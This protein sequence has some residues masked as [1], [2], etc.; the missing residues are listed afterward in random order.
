MTSFM[1]IS[2]LGSLLAASVCFAQVG[3]YDSTQF[4]TVYKNT[5]M[6]DALVKQSGSAYEGAIEHVKIGNHQAALKLWDETPLPQD[7][8]TR[9]DSARLI[10]HAPADARE[11]VLKQAAGHKVLIINEAIYNPAHRVFAE[12]LLPALRKQGFTHF[13]AEWLSPYDAGDLAKRG[14]AF[15][16]GISGTYTDAPSAA[17]LLKTAVQQ[18]FSLFP[19]PAPAPCDGKTSEACA[20]LR[21]QA[22]AQAIADLLAADTA[23]RVVIFCTFSHLDERKSLPIRQLGSWIAELAHTDPLTVDQETMSPHSVPA[24]E[25]PY[26][27]LFAAKTAVKRPSVMLKDG[28]S[29]TRETGYADVLVFH[30][31]PKFVNH[32]PDYLTIG[33]DRKR[34]PVPPASKLKAGHLY[35]AMAYI[36]GMDTFFTVPDDIIEIS[37]LKQKYDFCLRPGSY[38]IQFVGEDGKVAQT[39]KAEVK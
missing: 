9:E 3:P 5:L 26:Y 32:R 19:Y 37:D 12:S 8:L 30:P 17:N 10:A 21:E 28:Q 7:I 29:F 35:L 13:A 25:D 24:A 23:A 38:T 20:Q 27:T 18:G 11:F 22:Q 31:R 15:K 1:R 16:A 36:N 39:L 33:N 2:L 14:Y 6:I 4:Y 34:L